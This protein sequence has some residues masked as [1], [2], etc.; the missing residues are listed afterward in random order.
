MAWISCR[1]RE[2]LVGVAVDCIDAVFREHC[3]WWLIVFS[4]FHWI[5]FERAIHMQKRAKKRARREGDSPQAELLRLAT[6]CGAQLDGLEIAHAATNTGGQHRVTANRALPAAH[7][8]AIIP[9]ALLVTTDRAIASRLGKQ[10]AKKCRVFTELEMEQCVAGGGSEWTEGD[11]VLVGGRAAVVIRDMRPKHN[12]ATV[13][14]SDTNEEEKKIDA[15][16]IQ[17]RG[18]QAMMD[19]LLEGSFLTPRSF[20]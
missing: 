5:A 9:A 2:E 15:D 18:D 7:V 13:L 3:C 11:S 8:L 6:A 14:W 19:Q 17:Q 1:W 16:Q 12:R 20:C 4:N 10:I